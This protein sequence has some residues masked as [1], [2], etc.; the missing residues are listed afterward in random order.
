MKSRFV[1]YGRFNGTT[2]ATVTIDRGPGTIEVRPYRRR[3]SYTLPLAFVADM[4]MWRCLKAEAAEKRAAKK[5][6]KTGA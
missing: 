2:Q 3:K 6:K 4:V 1:V 5:K